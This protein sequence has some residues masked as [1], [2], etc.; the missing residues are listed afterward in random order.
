M[1]LPWWL[2]CCGLWLACKKD[3]PAAV[4]ALSP[5]ELAVESAYHAIAC[6][7]V[8]AIWSGN[9]Q[10]LAALPQPAPKSFGVE[11][12]AFKFADGSSKGFAP[13]GQVFFNDWRFDIFS[14]D[15]SAVA[16][17]IDH[18]GPYHLVKAGELRAY[19]EGRSKPVVVQALNGKDSMV[20]SD[21]RWASADSFEFVASCCGGA[22]AF[23]ASLKD[24][25]LVK[26]FDAPAA[27][28]GLERTGSGYEVVP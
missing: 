12:L 16:L 25:S 5:R 10:A 15:C 17:Q 14:P 28:R 22:Q 7:P 24:G 13:T 11:S 9:A 23:K 2:L 19:L 18:Y 21:G 6:G 3:P 8:T 27:P 1:R 26:V 20:H 4:P